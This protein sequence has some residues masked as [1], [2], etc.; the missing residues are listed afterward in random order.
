MDNKTASHRRR[1]RR[2][3]K[4]RG[5]GKDQWALA[6]A[7]AAQPCGCLRVDRP[8]LA[9]PLISQGKKKGGCWRMYDLFGYMF[10]D[11]QVSDL[12]DF[13]PVIG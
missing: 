4:I 12:L 2:R 8:L 11:A 10:K 6:D 1:R 7:Q 5:R 9:S 13:K 3:K